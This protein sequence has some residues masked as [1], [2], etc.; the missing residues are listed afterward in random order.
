MIAQERQVSFFLLAP[1][2]HLPTV[3]CKKH[4]I[5]KLKLEAQNHTLS[6]FTPLITGILW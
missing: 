3:C 5:E 2:F 4:E 6:F 1:L